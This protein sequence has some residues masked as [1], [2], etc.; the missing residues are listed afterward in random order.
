MK[1]AIES[2]MKMPKTGN[3]YEAELIDSFK[4]NAVQQIK[5]LQTSTDK[6]QLV[7]T[8]SWK[9]GDWKLATTRNTPR[10]WVSL[11]RLTNHIL[12]KYHNFCSPISLVLRSQSPALNPSI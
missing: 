11:D 12:N 5:I 7:I 3:I 6:Y 2:L 10:E 1:D 8:L 9:G 4:N